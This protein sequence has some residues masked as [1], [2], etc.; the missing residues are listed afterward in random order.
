WPLPTAPEARRVPTHSIADVYKLIGYHDPQLLSDIAHAW[1]TLVAKAQPDLI[2]SDFCP[3]LRLVAGG[4]CPMIAPGHGYTIPPPGRALP[5]IRPWHSTLPAESVMA[6][7][8]VLA[9]VNQVRAARGSRQS[10][11]LSDLFGGDRTFV[12]TVPFFDP[13]AAHRREPTFD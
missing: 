5:P 10:E 3:T 1:S 9:A 6:E 2:L 8:E 11:H 4:R 13:Y 7:R 12:C